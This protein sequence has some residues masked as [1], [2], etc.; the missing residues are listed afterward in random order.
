V[1]ERTLDY[2][3]DTV[4]AMLVALKTCDKAKRM[5]SLVVVVKAYVEKVD[6]G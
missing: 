3:E 2:D 4:V 5:D 1:A 6:H